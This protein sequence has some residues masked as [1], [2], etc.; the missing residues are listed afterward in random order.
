MTPD[1]HHRGA[2]RHLRQTNECVVLTPRGG[3]LHEAL[4]SRL[5]DRGWRP[6][7]VEDPHLAMAELCLRDH[8]RRSRAAVSDAMAEP[9]VL[10]LAGA[11]ARAGGLREMFQAIRR[12]LPDASVWLYANEEL[13]P[14]VGAKVNLGEGDDRRDA[15]A[16]SSLPG[17]RNRTGAAGVSAPPHTLRLTGPIT[18]PAETG[19]E[20]ESSEDEGDDEDEQSRITA[21][22]I[23]MLLQ[24]EPESDEQHGP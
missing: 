9:P 12:W 5:D 3:M 11:A 13:L 1:A 19:E 14:L 10:V 17:E 23:R 8:A 6:V 24:R 2:T 15:G 7:V 4:R 18:G 21:E 20:R 16:G 22:E